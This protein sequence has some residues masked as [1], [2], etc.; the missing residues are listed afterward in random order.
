MRVLIVVCVVVVFEAA[1]GVHCSLAFGLVDW[2]KASDRC[3]PW[4]ER[5]EIDGVC[6]RYYGVVCRLCELPVCV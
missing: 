2:Q 4:L 1:G 6:S 3:R 5:H